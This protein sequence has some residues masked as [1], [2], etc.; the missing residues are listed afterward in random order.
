MD[1]ETAALRNALIEAEKLKAGVKMRKKR[2]KQGGGG[3]A[4][5]E[6]PG[7]LD[8]QMHRVK[9]EPEMETAEDNVRKSRAPFS[10]CVFDT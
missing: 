5:A 8:N 9:E 2:G 4:V 7:P 1:D 10:K 3:E 6:R